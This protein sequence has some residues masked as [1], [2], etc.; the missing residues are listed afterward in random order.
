MRES[1]EKGISQVE[2]DPIDSYEK[3]SSQVEA[4]PTV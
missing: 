2:A 1:Y 4:D 3:G